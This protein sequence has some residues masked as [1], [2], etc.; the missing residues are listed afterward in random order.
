MHLYSDSTNLEEEE[1]EHVPHQ[2]Y[3]NWKTKTT[4]RDD[5]DVITFESQC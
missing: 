1:D 4:K 2:I 3:G 5:D